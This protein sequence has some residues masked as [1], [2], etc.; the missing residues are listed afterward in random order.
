MHTFHELLTKFLRKIHTFINLCNLSTYKVEPR[1]YEYQRMVKISFALSE[2]CIKLT[3][4]NWKTVVVAWISIKVC[5][6]YPE[7]RINRVCVNEVPLYLYALLATMVTKYKQPVPRFHTVD[8]G[9]KNIVGSWIQY[10][11]IRHVLITGM[12]DTMDITYKNTLGIWKN[13]CIAYIHYVCV[14][15]NRFQTIVIISSMLS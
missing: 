8:A 6:Y 1:W 3:E 7:I 12:S 9:Y 11:Y 4:I 14:Y 13:L 10:S 5:S 2:V 15:E